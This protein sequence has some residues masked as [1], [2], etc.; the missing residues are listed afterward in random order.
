M[1]VNGNANASEVLLQDGF[2]FRSMDYPLGTNTCIFVMVDHYLIG[3][4]GLCFFKDLSHIRGF[5]RTSNEED[6]YQF[7]VNS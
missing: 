6:E 1:G 7:S 5:S 4:W 3:C 2:N